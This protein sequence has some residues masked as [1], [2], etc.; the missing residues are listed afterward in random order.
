MGEIREK[1]D[2]QRP[3]RGTTLQTQKGHKKDMEVKGPHGIGL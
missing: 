1:P 2:L 3:V